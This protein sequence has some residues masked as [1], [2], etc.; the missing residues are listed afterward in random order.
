[1]EENIVFRKIVT[2]LPERMRQ[3]VC[4]KLQH[5]STR[6]HSAISARHLF[7]CVTVCVRN[8]VEEACIFRGHIPQM[9]A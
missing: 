1:V 5:I 2:S 3:Q 9:S 8:C 7:L 4:L 6:T